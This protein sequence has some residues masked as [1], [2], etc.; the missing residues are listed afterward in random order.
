[1]V[2][3]QL[4]A[5]MRPKRKMKMWVLVGTR[6]MRVSIAPMIKTLGI[7]EEEVDDMDK[8]QEEE[9]SMVPIFIA[10]KKVIMPLNSLNDKEGQIG[11]LMVKQGLLM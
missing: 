6:G 9:A 5:E 7:I 8:D 1:M 10:M 3:G 11:E 2:V 4:E